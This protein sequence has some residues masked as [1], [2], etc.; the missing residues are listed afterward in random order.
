MH[1]ALELHG[2]TAIR[3]VPVPVPLVVE[4]S[5]LLELP[6]PEDIPEAVKQHPSVARQTASRVILTVT[7]ET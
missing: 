4:L 2:P 3:V 5:P 7:M 1:S 6:L